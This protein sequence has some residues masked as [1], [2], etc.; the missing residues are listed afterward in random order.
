MSN[1]IFVSGNKSNELNINGSSMI[2]S[3]A[4]R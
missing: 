1:N 3:V 4:E 2:T